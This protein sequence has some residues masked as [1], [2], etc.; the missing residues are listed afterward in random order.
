MLFLQYKNE[1]V[2]LTEAKVDEILKDP[3]KKCYFKIVTIIETSSEIDS[4]KIYL[5]NFSKEFILKNNNNMSFE[6]IRLPM[7]KNFDVSFIHPGRWLIAGPSN[8]GKTTFVCKLL[9]KSKD[10]FNIDFERKIYCS[11]TR[12]TDDFENF[13]IVEEIEHIDFKNFDKSIN[14]IIILDDKMDQ[15]INS[16]LVSDIYT[17]LSHHNNITIIFL[18]QNLFPKS[19]YMRNMYLN[20]SY[21]V[22]MKNPTE[23]LQIVS[24]SKRLY[25]ASFKNKTY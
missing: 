20:S 13:E 17:K 12:P 10:L 19:K 5:T 8:S 23:I 4:A 24:L 22:L 18:T 6:R 16:E 11:D 14:T 21:I 2:K 3:M 7:N 9:A 25:R 1:K 15:A